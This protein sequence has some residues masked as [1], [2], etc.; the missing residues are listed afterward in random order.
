MTVIDRVLG[1]YFDQEDIRSAVTQYLQANPD[2]AATI[3]ESLFSAQDASMANLAVRVREMIKGYLEANVARRERFPELLRPPPGVNVHFAYG[4]EA[5]VS[6]DV[7]TDCDPPP[8]LSPVWCIGLI[9]GSAYYFDEDRREVTLTESGWE[10]VVPQTMRLVEDSRCLFGV[11]AVPI[12][13]HQEPDA[14]KP[15]EPPTEKD[16]ME[17][18]FFG[19]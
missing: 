19:R 11:T 13:T 8:C 4:G 15:A 2:A 14:P 17:R 5:L 16:E 18:F 12:D 6:H 3:F 9:D 1:Q 10:L 7:A